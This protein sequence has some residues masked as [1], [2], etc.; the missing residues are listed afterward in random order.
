[1]LFAVG[2]PCYRTKLSYS[3]HMLGELLQGQGVRLQQVQG[4]VLPMHTQSQHTRPQHTLPQHNRVRAA[5]PSL[6]LS[7]DLDNNPG[8][9]PPPQVE[10]HVHYNLPAT[11][12]RH[13]AK[14]KK[15]LRA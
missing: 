3:W 14:P 7:L 2:H 8:P 12:E 11:A 15:Q 9:V 13:S 5:Q 4:V 10:D 6:A 1:M